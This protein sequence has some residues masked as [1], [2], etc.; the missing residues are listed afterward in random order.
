MFKYFILLNIISV[1]TLPALGQNTQPKRYKDIVFAGVTVTKDVPYGT[2]VPA[3]AHNKTLL[4]DVYQPE[5]D[6][7]RNARPLIIWMHGGG[8]K[9]GSKNAAG[10]QIWSSSFA[11]R[12]YVCAAIN[13]QLSKKHPLANVKDLVH[14]CADAIEDV[15]QAM[16]FFKENQNKYGID[17][18]RI[19]L[20]GNSAGGMIAFQA[21]YSTP[22]ELAKLAGDSA[23]NLLA[24][25]PLKIAAVVNFWGALFNLGWLNNANVPIVSVHGR[26]DKIVP[27]G[28]TSSSFYGSLPIHV[29][30]DS[31]HIPNRLKVYEG[32]S[33]E[34]Q[35]HFNPL[36]AGGAAKRRWMEAGQFAAD[37]LYDTI[38]N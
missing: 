17:T 30:A 38:F 6:S 23:N 11:Q 19:I 20:A 13:Y 22:A 36:F 33:H 1:A 3:S 37:F 10:M 8:F 9:F 2:S 35:K 14:G 5:G 15:K 16:S 18:S 32:F 27:I 24:N 25:Q 7:T 26:N 4:L 21:A 28:H 31:L 34:L 29:T 12:G